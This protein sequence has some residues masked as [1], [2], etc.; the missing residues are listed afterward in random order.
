MVVYTR[1][2]TSGECRTPD[3]GYGVGD[4]DARQAA[5]ARERRLPNAG[6]GVSLSSVGN[7][8]WNNNFARIISPITDRQLCIIINKFITDGLAICI[9][10]RNIDGGGI[11]AQNVDEQ[12]E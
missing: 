10:H 6:H 2:D 9:L 3:T 7:R 1:L 4:G 5:T 8:F 12:G 11:N